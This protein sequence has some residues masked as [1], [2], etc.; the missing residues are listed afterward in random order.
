MIAVTVAAAL[1]ACSSESEPV[2]RRGLTVAQQIASERDYETA[3]EDMPKES[4]ESRGDE[5][6]NANKLDVSVSELETLPMRDGAA[7]ILDL[8]KSDN[9]SESE[10]V[11]V[12]SGAMPALENKLP[13]AESASESEMREITSDSARPTSYAANENENAALVQSESDTVAKSELA[14]EETTVLQTTAV[15]NESVRSY[16][17]N[18]NS[19]KFHLS[20][21]SSAEKIKNENR[22]EYKGTRD[23][24][25][26][27]GY[28]PCK[29]CEP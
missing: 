24:I 10:N 2:E 8:P 17:L 26:E 23:E 14:T 22:S 5:H 21:C 1:A 27:K 11:C 13:D 29:R 20:D 16:V 25:I 7:V 4:G 9:E 15:Q 12:S 18:T 6:D 3:V 19:K 28:S